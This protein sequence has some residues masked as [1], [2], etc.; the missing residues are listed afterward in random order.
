MSLLLQY[1]VW[2][3]TL[4]VG[5]NLLSEGEGGEWVTSSRGSRGGGIVIRVNHM[6]HS[7][8]N[9]THCIVGFFRQVAV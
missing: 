6:A 5:G 7:K 9:C 1:Q 8:Q 2:R 3:S 4:G